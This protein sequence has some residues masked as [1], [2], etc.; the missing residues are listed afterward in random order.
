MDKIGFAD[1]VL[2]YDYKIRP[3]G[4]I[5]LPEIPEIDYRQSR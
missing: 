4:N 2:A 5:Q 1:A 3:E